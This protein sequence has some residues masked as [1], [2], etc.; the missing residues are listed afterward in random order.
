MW[1]CPNCKQGI[2]DLIIAKTDIEKQAKFDELHTKFVNDKAEFL[3]QKALM[4]A[5]A[6]NHNDYKTT[7]G[8]TWFVE[9]DGYSYSIIARFT[10]KSLVWQPFSSRIGEKLYEPNEPKTK[11]LNYLECPACKHREY[12]PH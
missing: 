10:I 9:Y 7:F 5:K 12:L 8:R 6:K 11:C 3:L 1:K 4:D 2:K